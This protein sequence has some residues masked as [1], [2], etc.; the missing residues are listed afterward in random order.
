MSAI[1]AAGAG[2]TNGEVPLGEA[3]AFWVLG[4]VSLAGALGTVLL[5]N[6]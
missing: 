2:L 3:V 5:R 4:P 1:L 6:A